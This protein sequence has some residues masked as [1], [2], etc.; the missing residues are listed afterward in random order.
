MAISWPFDS[1][2]TE[3][4]EGNPIYSRTYSANV[5]AR[6]LQK[7]FRNGVF[8]DVSTGLQ[9]VQSTGMAVTVKP[10][11]ALING[12]H[13]YEE[14]ERGM[15]IAAANASLDRID[16]IV[17]RLNLGVSALSI[18]LYVLTGTPAAS[19]T[20]PEL[21]RNAS[22]YELGL[23]NV[24]IVKNTTSIPQARITDTRLD[25]DRC[26]VVASIVGDTDTSA[27]Y[28]QIQDDLA[29]F[30][31]TEQAAFIAWFENVQNIL[32]E[33]AAGNLLNLINQV[34]G[35][36]QL[37]TYTNPADLGLTVTTS[38]TMEQVLAAMPNGSQLM[39]TPSSSTTS[40]LTPS[41]SR[42]GTLLIHRLSASRITMLW[43]SSTIAAPIYRAT[44][45]YSGTWTIG[46]WTALLDAS[47][48]QNDQLGTDATKVLGAPQGKVLGD[49]IDA[50]N[51][52]LAGTTVW[53]GTAAEGDTKTVSGFTTGKLYAFY[54]A[55]LGLEIVIPYRS[56]TA[57]GSVAA[58][59]S[60]GERLYVLKITSSGD[61]ITFSNCERI[62]IMS[63]AVNGT[64]VS[65]GFSIAA[66]R[67]LI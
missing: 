65:A 17:C 36:R 28:A 46:A 11:D 2:V 1:T 37:L 6:I 31:S 8:N 52:R 18:D 44:A 50:I 45:S 64:K 61:A 51:A 33:N 5:L 3:D 34:S 19:P 63:G 25:S 58:P 14:S 47:M 38:T 49:E 26:G 20:A 66:I 4:T 42:D 62:D 16:T 27:Y 32:D 59:I 41:T 40:N 12:R 55:T 43:Y 7:Y 57:V 13:F 56:S 15:M 39:F 29:A 60:G 30:K 35:A 10:G 21:T 54:L 53:S 24:L 67:Q 22:V 48:I 9:V 23:A